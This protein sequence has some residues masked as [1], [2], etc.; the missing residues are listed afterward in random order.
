MI[1][2]NLIY[3]LKTILSNSFAYFCISSTKN[4]EGCGLGIL[5]SAA[6][7]RNDR[8]NYG[9]RLTK[10]VSWHTTVCGICKNDAYRTDA[11]RNASV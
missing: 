1:P 4:R 8:L 2:K 6:L 5:H 3:I 9:E 11:W 7:R 10:Y